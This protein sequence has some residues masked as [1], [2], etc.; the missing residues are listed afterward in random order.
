LI[1]SLIAAFLLDFIQIHYLHSAYPFH[2]NFTV[3]NFLGTLFQIQ[4]IPAL[5][6]NLR[7]FGTMAQLWTLSIEWWLYMSSGYIAYVVVP[8]CQNHRIKLSDVVKAL[9]LCYPVLDYILRGVVPVAPIIWGIGF[10]VFYLQRQLTAIESKYRLKAALCGAIAFMLGVGIWKKDAYSMAFILS[11]AL[12]MLLSL[13]CAQENNKKEIRFE[14]SLRFFAS[15]S[16]SLYL[17]HYSVMEFYFRGYPMLSP[18]GRFFITIIVSNILAIV[19]S[20]VF[21]SKG[22]NLARW[23]E[24]R[25]HVGRRCDDR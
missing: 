7:Y 18:W 8:K 5:S 16:Y 21:E 12:V 11:I 17:L 19:F 6:Q 3:K 23:L 10:S 25:L 1:P 15:Y 2:E 9:L 20:K 22:K 4:M 24:M 14:K 13:L